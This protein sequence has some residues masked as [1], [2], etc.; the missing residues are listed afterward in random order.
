M[1]RY[2]ETEKGITFC[3]RV[4]PRASRSEIVG[5][6]DGSL[7][8]RLAAPP[9]DGEANAECVRFFAKELGISRT[10]VEIVSGLSSKTKI[11]RVSGIQ[12]AQLEQLVARN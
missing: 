9:V 6:F 12:S 10:N 4:Q 11:I 1:I 5:E 7:K 2:N 8:I 3:I